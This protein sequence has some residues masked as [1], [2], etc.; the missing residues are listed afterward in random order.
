MLGSIQDFFRRQIE[1]KL[2]DPDSAG[3]SGLQ[4]A[5]AALL[6]EMM[7]MDR[8]ILEAERASVV[9]TLTREFGVEAS[10]LDEL[11]A[12]A[13]A[14]A[15]EA[16]DYFQFTSL[17]NRSASA[18]QKV[19]IIESMWRVA[20]ADGHLDDHEA[21]LMKKVAGLLH[22]PHADYVM[23]KTRARDSAAPKG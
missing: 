12:L 23:A 3:D 11:L 22:I 7:R 18:V 17:I 15:R 8:D 5:T 2:A 6:V 1:P 9:A 21:H 20:F 19:R 4:L 10:A 13:E 16:T 14:E